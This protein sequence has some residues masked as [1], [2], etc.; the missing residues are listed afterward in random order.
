MRAALLIAVV[1]AGPATAEPWHGTWSAD[2]AWCVHADKIGSHTPAPI[3]LGAT[4]FDGY[5]NS[6]MVGA[7]ARLGAA[8]AWHLTLRCTGEGATY[9]DRRTVVLEPGGGV[10]W[11]IMP[12]IDPIRF[13]RCPE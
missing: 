1:V 2:P 11:H 4:G 13:V 10:S 3:R 7:V 12:D 6:C 5:E 8:N 9:D